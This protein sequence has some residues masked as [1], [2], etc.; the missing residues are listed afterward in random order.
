MDGPS[1][2][3][4]ASQQRVLERLVS[5]RDT[6]AYIVTRA[7]QVLAAAG[8]PGDTS[9]HT[10]ADRTARK[11]LAR[12]LEQGASGLHDAPRRGR[13]ATTD[14][15]DLRAVLT[16]PLYSDS[17]NW[18]SRTI[19]MQTGLSQSTI[20][21]LWR[22]VYRSERPALDERVPRGGLSL[23]A[24]FSGAQGS[25]L[26]VS[27]AE[28]HAMGDAGDF[29]RSPLRPA[30]QVILATQ[31]VASRAEVSPPSGAQARALADVV[32]ERRDRHTYAL[33]SSTSVGRLVEAAAPGL[34][35]VHVQEGRWQGL[36]LELGERLS[37]TGREALAGAQQQARKWAA[38]PHAPWTWDRALPAP[39]EQAT[40]TM[41]RRDEMPRPS[42]EHLVQTVSQW[43]HREIMEGRLGAGDRVTETSLAR[44]THSSRGHVREALKELASREI[45]RLVPHRGAVIPSPT[46]DD[47]VEI[48]AARRSLGALLVRRAA[49]APVPGH[50]ATL[51][52]SL[53]AML[54]TARGGD[55]LATGEQDLVLQ[56][57]IAEMAGMQRI[58]RMYVG[59]NDQLRMLVAVLRLRYA[60]SIPEMCRDNVALVD[61]VRQHNGAD[62]VALWNAKMNAAA[63]YMMEQVKPS[64]SGAARRH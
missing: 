60:Y 39:G 10:S 64:A 58:A 51:D 14:E 23:D 63:H 45:I 61:H 11:W 31:V 30:L 21:R 26:I 41:R 20:A 57:V 42:G 27:P 5:S 55:A 33:C 24:C 37:R 22:R 35:V 43:L 62:A 38:S 9:M 6:P 50:L 4:S 1:E 25:V 3:L 18:T 12:F 32:A 16:A 13:P 47:V 7:R 53:E 48:Y 29:M 54:V 52:A 2:I 40:A 34:T 46:L 44:L 8:V 36:L 19:A 17:P 15:D 49:E 28:R 59:L 56:E